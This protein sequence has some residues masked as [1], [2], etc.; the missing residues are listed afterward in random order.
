V[1]LAVVLLLPSRYAGAADGD[2][3]LS[4]DSDEEITIDAAELIYDQ[5]SS[6]VSASGE[7]E[8]RRGESVLRADTIRVNQETRAASAHG[9]AVLTDPDVTIRASEMEI[10]LLDETGVLSDAQIRSDTHGYSLWGDRIEKRVGQSYHIEN[11]R[12][13]TCDCEDGAPSWSITGDTIDVELDG[14]GDIRGGRFRI[15]DKTVFYVPRGAFPVYRERHTGL[16]FPRLGFS[17]RRGLQILQPFYWAIDKSQD[18]TVSLDIETAQRFGLIGEYRYAW[19]PRTA[20]EFQAMYFNEAIRGRATEVSISGAGP[21]DVPEN[22]WAVVGHHSQGLGKFDGYL[23]LM[24]VGDD[25]FLREINTFTIDESQDVALRTRPFTSSRA[26]TIRRWNRGFVQGEGV[27]YQN[28]V[29]R[30]TF[31]IQQ[32]PSLSAE[33][34]TELFRGLLASADAGAS[35]FERSTGI[36]GFRFDVSPKLEL[37]LPLGKDLVGSVSA[38]FRETAYA[39]TQD[40]MTGGFTGEGVG[41]IDLPTTSHRE[42]VEIRGLLST[43]LSRIYSFPHFGLDKIKHTIEPKI[44]YLLIPSVNQEDLPIF[45]GLDRLADRNV[46]SYGFASRLLGRR[47]GDEGEGGEVFE[48]TRL[49]LT[50]SFDFHE[51]VPQPGSPGNFDHLSDIDLDMR[52]S[53]SRNATMV[54]KSTF[55]TDRAALTSATVGVRL[56]EST[57]SL[58][59][60]EHRL[61]VR[62]SIG[63]DYRFIANNAVP[64]TSVVEQLDTNITLRL[65]DRFAFRH[66]LRYNLAASELLSNFFGV[67]LVSA[68]NCWSLDI[69][70]SDNTNPNEIQVQA[71]ISLVGLGSAGGGSR[72]GLSD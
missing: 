33:G 39:L 51:N 44:E 20:G 49:S 14:Y 55:D 12:F 7:V 1:L 71:Q 57:P 38:A 36:T 3:G 65:T 54:L 31:V 58:G 32:T 21:V 29:G 11:G 64:D 59:E 25:V 52:V 15:L 68:C 53:P 22:R 35:N 9:N 46:I 63:V 23:D 72:T 16:L 30:E 41:F 34:Q 4:V 45:D 66:A 17:N 42:T 27:F 6:V 8:I 40:E 18:L 19:S 5:K 69:G 56:N 61:S 67:R 37:R 48:L 13:T 70:V 28:L 43:G 26:G 10:N 60:I 24:L 47:S 62:S 50:Q 2:H